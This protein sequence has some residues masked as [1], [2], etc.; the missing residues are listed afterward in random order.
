MDLVDND[1]LD[2]IYVGSFSCLSSDNVPLFWCSHNNLGFF[3]LLLRQ[4][5]VSCQ[6][7]YRNSV[8]LEPPLKAAHHF[9]DERL[10]GSDVDDLEAFEV[11]SAVCLSFLG[12]RL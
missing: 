4:V 11:D 2:Q 1:E 3:N 6:L 7:L 9:G 5:D 10:H 12:N 8:F